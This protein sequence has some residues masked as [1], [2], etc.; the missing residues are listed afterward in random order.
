MREATA[1]DIPEIVRITNH[2]YVVEAF[3]LQGDRTDPAGVAELMESGRFLVLP[4]EE[5]RLKGSVF[6][7]PEGERW[8]LGLLAVAPECQKQG[9]GGAVMKAAEAYCRE[10][11]G[12]FLDLTVVNL[13]KELFAFYGRL[14]FHPYD[15]KPFPR[16]SKMIV[17]IH[18]V[19]MTKALVPATEL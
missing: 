6:L 17:P 1:L 12:R 2:A 19:A 18:L 14:G 15:V 10:R 3:C 4:G 13:R 16:P 5:G 9:I 8:Y 11:G 7:K